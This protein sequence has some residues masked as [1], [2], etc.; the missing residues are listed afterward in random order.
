M[1]ELIEKAEKL[2]FDKTMT[3]YS[4][5]DK[6]AVKD[7]NYLNLCLIQKFLRDEKGVVLCIE[8]DSDTEGSPIFTVWIN[9]DYVGLE[10]KDYE[11]ALEEGIKTALKQIER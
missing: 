7:T 9:W 8:S 2:G 6:E 11:Q 1:K 4:L 5:T 3:P 10:F